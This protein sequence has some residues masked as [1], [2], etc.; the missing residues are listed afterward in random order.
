MIRFWGVFQPIPLRFAESGLF[1]LLSQDG[2]PPSAENKKSLALRAS[3]I[4]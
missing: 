4:G 3:G 2:K 1:C